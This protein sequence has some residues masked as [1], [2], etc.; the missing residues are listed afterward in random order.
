MFFE[1]IF[2]FCSLVA[3]CAFAWLR[4]CAFVFLMLFMLFVCAKSFF[5]FFLNK[6]FKTVLITSFILLLNLCCYKHEFFNHY[7]LFQLSQYFSIITIFFNYHNLFQS[8][9]LFSVLKSIYFFVQ[10]DISTQSWRTKIMAR[11]KPIKL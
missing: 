6:G 11:I 9:I 4:F 5:F 8:F 10:S 7:Y 3:F 2:Y 1:H